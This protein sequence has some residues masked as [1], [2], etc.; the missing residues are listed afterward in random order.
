MASESSMVKQIR[1]RVEALPNTH[2]KK[3]WSTAT[4]RDVDLL[5]VTHGLAG[6]YEIKVP[7]EKPTEWQAH[8]LDYW[9]AA[10]ADV[11]WFDSVDACVCHIQVLSARGA[12]MQQLYNDFVEGE[13]LKTQGQLPDTA[14][15]CSED[16]GYCDKHGY[17]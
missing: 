1:A 11:A 3:L 6:F 17:H 8:R 9:R 10:G 15:T 12:K 2:I 7:G 14:G 16:Y 4:T 13:I 5:V